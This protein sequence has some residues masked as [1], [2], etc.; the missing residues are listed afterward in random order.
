MLMESVAILG[1]TL[2]ILAVFVRSGNADY[3]LATMEN[4]VWMWMMSGLKARM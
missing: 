2:C 3:A 4:S 1:I